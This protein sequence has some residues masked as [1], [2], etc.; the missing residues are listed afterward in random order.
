MSGLSIRLTHKIMAIGIVGL[1]GLLAF[2]AI[3]R[4]GS[5]S[6]DASRAVA[7]EG[8]AI[9]N[10]DKQISIA[11]LEARRAEKDFQL[12]RDESYNR[13]HSELSAGIDRDLEKL[14]SMARSGGFNGML[15]RIEIIHRGF[16]NYAKHFAGLSQAEINL[17]L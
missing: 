16:A 8:R 14:K 12:R 15:D 1:I 17:G 10:L 9:S 13:R 2:G 6:Q 3:Y 5:W 11:M 7:G 4:I